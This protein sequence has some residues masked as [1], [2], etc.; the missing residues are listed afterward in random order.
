MNGNPGPAVGI[1]RAIRQFYQNNVKII[2]IDEL[3]DSSG[4]YDPIFDESRVI[5]CF[6]PVNSNANQLIQFQEIFQIIHSNKNSIIIPVSY[7]SQIFYFTQ[8][9]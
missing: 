5:S 9:L 7:S 6:G 1:A 3:T 2:G 8:S 4:L